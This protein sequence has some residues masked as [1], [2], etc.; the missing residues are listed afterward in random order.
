MEACCGVRSEVH[1]ETLSE[2]SV[3]HVAR[4]YVGQGVLGETSSSFVLKVVF[5]MPL[6]ESESYTNFEVD[7]FNLCRNNLS[8]LLDFLCPHFYPL[9]TTCA[10]YMSTEQC[11]FSAKVGNLWVKKLV[12]CAIF[13]NGRPR[14][15]YSQW[16]IYGATMMIKGSL[17]LGIPIV[18]RICSKKS[19][20]AQIFKVL[21]DK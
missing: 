10:S 5:G 17:L 2:V 12:E 18:K 21:R 3:R 6:P 4:F 8:I 1:R 16:K 7:R 20:F 14:F 9:C 13:G 19:N 15:A 11:V